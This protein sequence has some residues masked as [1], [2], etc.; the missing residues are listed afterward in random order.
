MGLSSKT[1][2]TQNTET[3]GPS[4]YSQPYIDAAAA[5]LRPAY[6][7]SMSVMNKFLPQLDNVASYYGDVMGGKFLNGNPFL[8][9]VVNASNADI[10][11]SVNATFMPRF[12]SGYHAKA[13]AKQLGDNEARLRYGDYATERGYMNNAAAQMPGVAATATALP[14]VP[15]QAYADS[16][17]SLLGKYMT[18]NSSGTQKQSGG[19][20]GS[21]LGSALSLG[22]AAIS[23][24]RAKEGI[25][26]VGQT[27]GGLPVYT[28][29]YKGDPQIH[30]GVM[31]QD[32]AQLQ[33][34]ALGP[35][36]G[37]YMSVN[38]EEVR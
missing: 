12:G 7:Q 22:A 25:S 16:V 6:D 33:P 36:V 29:R 34:D 3:V 21:I 15:S 19:L 13:L 24:A 20:L 8:D 26:R 11:D 37:G 10:T 14:M 23:D 38:Y 30:M 35:E 2:K 18:S 28:F 5:T 1:V 32:V 4:A 31:A 9:S 27:D 17:N